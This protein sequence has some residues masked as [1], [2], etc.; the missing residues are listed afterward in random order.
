MEGKPEKREQ[1]LKVHEKGQ[2]M[3]LSK[4]KNEEAA[5]SQGLRLYCILLISLFL[6]GKFNQTGDAFAAP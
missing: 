2:S 3:G 5:Q 1:F 4:G 6:K